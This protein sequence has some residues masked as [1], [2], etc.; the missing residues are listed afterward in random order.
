MGL[1]AAIVLIPPLVVPL[2]GIGLILLFLRLCRWLLAGFQVASPESP[3]ALVTVEKQPEREPLGELAPK[4]H[5]KP[6]MQERWKWHQWALVALVVLVASIVHGL[7]SRQTNELSESAK[8]AFFGRRSESR[9]DTTAKFEESLRTELPK[10]VGDNITAVDVSLDDANLIW[11]YQRQG[12]GQMSDVT[13]LD[14]IASKACESGA[15]REIAKYRLGVKY[16]LIDQS[17]KPLGS[18]TVN[19]C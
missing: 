16:Q 15:I 13:Y 19:R 18:R 17:G 6:P 1:A 8:H 5:A 14:S 4:Q 10:A 7:V 3:A 2:L 9:I 11:T 12:P